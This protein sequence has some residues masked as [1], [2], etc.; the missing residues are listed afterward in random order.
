MEPTKPVKLCKDC[1]HMER[2][3]YSIPVCYATEAPIDFIYGLKNG[4]CELMRSWNC[5]LP[6]CGPEG[7]WFEPKQ[8]TEAD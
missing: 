4:T 1:R 6:C 2:M 3:E 5:L 8:A 7:R